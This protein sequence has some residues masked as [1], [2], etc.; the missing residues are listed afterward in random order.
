M[1]YGIKLVPAAVEHL[2]ALT[3]RERANVLS[4]LDEQLLDQ[5]DRE[6]R[7][8]KRFRPNPIAE[9]ALRIGDLRVYYDIDL[10]QAVIVVMAV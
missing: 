3:A 2:R 10:P 8:R 7:N 4:A 5:P 6:T 1:K 9:W